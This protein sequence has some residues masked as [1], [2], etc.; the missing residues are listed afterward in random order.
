MGLVSGVVA[1]AMPVVVGAQR[2]DPNASTCHHSHHHTALS[3]VLGPSIDWITPAVVP[4]L[5]DA[6]GPQTF[7]HRAC[8]PMMECP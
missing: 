3:A 5:C 4:R 8:V 7:L 2:A 1:I 6:L